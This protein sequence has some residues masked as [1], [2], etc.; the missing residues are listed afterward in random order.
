MVD[1]A[2][3]QQDDGSGAAQQGSGIAAEDGGH[4]LGEGTGQDADQDGD[5]H[6]GHQDGKELG[7]AGALL[8]LIH[9]GGSLGHRVVSVHLN[10]GD[11]LL[12]IFDEGQNKGNDTGDGGQ[13][14]A[15]LQHFGDVNVGGGG[16][17]LGGALEH[18]V[19]GQS[20]TVTSQVHGDA[21]HHGGQAG[22]QRHGDQDGAHQSGG[23]SGPE[24]G[25][26][27]IHDGGNDPESDTGSF[28]QLGRG[29]DHHLVGAHGLQGS[30]HGHHQG[31][32]QH[33]VTQIAHGVQH[34]VE[35]SLRAADHAAAE[36][37]PDDENAQ[38]TGGDHVVLHD[39]QNDDGY[40]DR[41]INEMQGGQHH[42][43]LSFFGP[44]WPIDTDNYTAVL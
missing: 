15:P 5:V 24:E 25:C 1:G 18:Q 35:H 20:H 30:Q 13:D 26:A 2:G 33:D 9:G 6:H 42:D 27:H 8:L 19:A 40:D 29:G 10:A 14:A 38:D 28:Q 11:D 16:G 17:Q 12:L 41:Q 39:H 37:D 36:P 44:E 7:I 34:A 22:L 23:G 21:G 4:A 31:D 43:T 32:D 3:Q